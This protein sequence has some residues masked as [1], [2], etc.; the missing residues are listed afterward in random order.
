MKITIVLFVILTLFAEICHAELR[1]LF[2]SNHETNN[3][4]LYS[5]ATNGTDLTRLTTTGI[6]E[7]APAISP[8]NVDIAFVDKSGTASNIYLTTV[9]GEATVQLNNINEALCVQ[10]AT[11]NTI[12]FLA[13]KNDGGRYYFQLYKINTD[14]SDEQRVYSDVF[15]DY[16]MGAMDFSINQA[17]Q[18][19][20][21]SSISND[22]SYIY[23]GGV[24]DSAAHGTLIYDNSLGDRYA[25]ELS[26]DTSKFAFCA[27]FGAGNHKLYSDNAVPGGSAANQICDTYCGNP[28]WIDNNSI[29]FTRTSS[30]NYGM[31]SYVGDIWRVNSD[32]SSLTNLTTLGTCAYSSS[33]DL[34]P[35]PCLF[36]IYNLLIIIYYRKFIS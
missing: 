32:G 22:N 14:G 31:A 9:F 20:Y 11:T 30:P 25:P 36:I 5:M 24:T 26:P 19:V 4:E 29:T 12:Y 35:E 27:D 7:W 3:Y 2:T 16:P 34:V 15:K 1:V 10:F 33:F 8:N 23:Y 28:S 17:N 6:D 18:K 21:L 13:I